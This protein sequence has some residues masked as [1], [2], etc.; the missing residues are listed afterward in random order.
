[1]SAGNKKAEPEKE[2]KQEKELQ[3]NEQAYERED[4]ETGYAKNLTEAT[5]LKANRK[6]EVIANKLMGSFDDKGHYEIPKEIL[7]ELTLFKKLVGVKTENG[8][9]LR[10]F[11]KNLVFEFLLKFNGVDKEKNQE[12]AT[13]FLVERIE[14]VNGYIINKMVTPVA[15]YMALPSD[16]FQAICYEAF[17]VVKNIDDDSI[18]A[19]GGDAVNIDKRIAYLLAVREASKNAYIE[20]EEL[21]FN[22]RLSILDSI[23]QGTLILSE[24]AK[25]RALLEKYF[26]GND[27]NKFRAL[28]ELLTSILEANPQIMAQMPVFDVMITPL[29]NKYL[30][31]TI[32]VSKKIK[33]SEKYKA[34]E[35][36][37]V[38]V[39]APAPVMGGAVK[40]ETGGKKPAP[41]PSGPKKGG[42]P[43]K[44]GGG[45][46]KGGGGGSKGG[47]KGKGG[48]K[49]KGK[50]QDNK[51]SGPKGPVLYV[52]PKKLPKQEKEQAKNLEPKA[53]IKKAEIKKESAKSEPATPSKPMEQK[54]AEE[55]NNKTPQDDYN[56]LVDFY[57]DANGVEVD[58]Q[59]LEKTTP[60]MQTPEIG[61]VEVKK[62]QKEPTKKET[63]DQGEISFESFNENDVDIDVTPKQESQKTE[64]KEPQEIDEVD[65][66][67]TQKKEDFSDILDEIDVIGS[68]TKK[69][70]TDLG[71]EF[72]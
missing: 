53:E 20:I 61:E 54:K 37:P 43:K 38:A 69:R 23:P 44:S 52:P 8:V 55:V 13:L 29:N 11:Y 62:E 7:T 6:Y 40:I 66:K 41:K 2:L 48:D 47:G 60:E 50:K 4:S 22:T 32:A 21:Y 17:H 35:N 12:S 24:F 26:I 34:L 57:E 15:T 58:Q 19:L 51:K 10:S 56:G 72:A 27:R 45:G 33:I 25:K 63:N 71:P 3:E 28:N 59:N 39:A 70:P 42:G 68:Q 1:M 30:E 5:M 16:N 18:G 9:E 65:V 31:A 67:K 14:K 36:A 64:K 46:G 49:K